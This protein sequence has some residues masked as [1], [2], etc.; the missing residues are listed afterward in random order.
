L[1]SAIEKY[2][3]T[4][5]EEYLRRKVRR[6]LEGS[7]KYFVESCIDAEQQSQEEGETVQSGSRDH[8]S[9]RIIYSRAEQ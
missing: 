3:Q 1:D 2:E 9:K 6:A 8:I 7:H 4:R 5:N